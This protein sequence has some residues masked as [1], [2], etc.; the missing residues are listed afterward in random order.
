MATAAAWFALREPIITET[1]AY[2]LSNTKCQN[3]KEELGGA[4][5]SQNPT[6]GPSTLVWGQ[7][8]VITYYG[9]VRDPPRDQP[10]VG[11]NEELVFEGPVLCMKR[12][13]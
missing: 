6:P 3:I 8:A 5:F 11:L 7:N 9:L 2:I 13:M 4:N 10:I 12:E 1:L